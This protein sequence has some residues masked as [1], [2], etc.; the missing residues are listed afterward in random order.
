MPS[1]TRDTAPDRTGRAPD[2]TGREG[3]A[4]AHPTQSEHLMQSKMFFTNENDGA[5]SN[6]QDRFTLRNTP[7]AEAQP[8]L[9]GEDVTAEQA[10]QAVQNVLEQVLGD[11]LGDAMQVEVIRDAIDKAIEQA[12]DTNVA[13]RN[14]PLLRPPKLLE[15]LY[16]CESTQD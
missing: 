14:L 3:G 5:I 9:L 16:T 13:A 6:D 1:L 11:V 2:R 7:V 15:H 10:V 12:E 8:F 4:R